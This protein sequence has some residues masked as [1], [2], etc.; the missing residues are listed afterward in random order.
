MKVSQTK[1][2]A[3]NYLMYKFA[4]YFVL[5]SCNMCGAYLYF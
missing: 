2:Y 5:L 1:T 4:F 3:N